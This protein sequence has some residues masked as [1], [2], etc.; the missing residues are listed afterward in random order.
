MAPASFQDLIR[1]QSATWLEYCRLAWSHSAQPP[2]LEPSRL[3]ID[4]IAY[5][6]D[7]YRWFETRY[8]EEFNEVFKQVNSIVRAIGIVT[9]DFLSIWQQYF[10]PWSLWKQ[11]RSLFAFSSALDGL[12][13]EHIGIA[14]AYVIGQGVPSAAIDKLLDTRD[15]SVPRQ[16][17]ESLSSFSLIAYN[18]ALELMRGLSVPGK[19]EDI[20]LHY[21][22]LMYS[23]MWK[24]SVERYTYPAQVSDV[25]LEEYTSGE[26]RLLSSVF[27]SITIEW[28]FELAGTE[29]S[30]AGKK[31]CV[32]FR[33]VRQLNDEIIDVRDD[34]RN[35]ILTY[36]ILHSLASRRYGNH[37]RQL[38][39]E[40]WPQGRDSIEISDEMI[41]EFHQIIL[42]ADSFTATAEKSLSQLSNVMSFI[43]N[44]FD[45]GNAFDISLI[46]NQRLSTLLKWAN[47]NWRHV[48]DRYVPYLISPQPRSDA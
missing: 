18:T 2:Q 11:L 30:A 39:A 8:Q 26:S 12:A 6:Q 22:R 14:T 42:D 31:A 38:L 21:T 24:E 37:M 40:A 47:N 43:M 48:P 33:R 45:T 4:P 41:T 32:S 7:V 35:G 16:H 23:Y 10:D 9:E 28:A 25:Q 17:L 13:S 46:V 3:Y 15:D 44:S 29:L 34:F 5:S 27:Y 1:T 20:F 19:V 36:P